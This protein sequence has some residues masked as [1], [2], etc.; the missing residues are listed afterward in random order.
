MGQPRDDGDEQMLDEILKQ[1]TGLRDYLDDM[2]RALR[3]LRE[4]LRD[5]S[6][7]IDGGDG[8]SKPA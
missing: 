7:T 3:V 6:G 2:V 8:G 5:R 1:V 4:R